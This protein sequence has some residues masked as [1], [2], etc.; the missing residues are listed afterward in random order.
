MVADP[1]GSCIRS[2][3]GVIAPVPFCCLD[4]LDK[5]SSRTAFCYSALMKLSSPADQH[6]ALVL[7]TWSPSERQFHFETLIFKC[8]VRACIPRAAALPIHRHR[9]KRRTGRS[10]ISSE[11]RHPCRGSLYCSMSL[12][13]LLV[14]MTSGGREHEAARIDGK[15][16]RRAL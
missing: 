8:N 3:R 4:N 12:S 10:D 11:G 6:N 9:Q 14:G 13:L 7:V 2:F 5:F 15:L 16:F 1:G